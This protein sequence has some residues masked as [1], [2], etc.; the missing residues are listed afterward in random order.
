MTT[1]DRK[2]QIR[3]RKRLLFA[4]AAL[5]VIA[6]VWLIYRI[7]PSKR[8]M[9]GAVYFGVEEDGIGIAVNGQLTGST[10]K[11]IGGRRYLDAASASCAK[12]SVFY[13]EAE[14][15]LIVTTPTEKYVFSHE[16]HTA[17][18]GDVIWQDG[19]VYVA[20]S[21]LETVTGASFL[22]FPD[23]ERIVVENR[24]DTVKETFSEAAP[25][26][27]RAG[28]KSPVLTICEA[29]TEVYV[30]D[31]AA[32]G[33]GTEGKIKGWTHVCT[34]DGYAGYVQDRF[35]TD[36]EEKKSVYENPAGEYT[37][38]RLEEPVNMVFHQTTDQASNDALGRSIEGIS[39]V[40]VIAPTWFFLD[41][42]DG[43]VRSLASRTYVETAHAAGLKVFAVFNDFDGSVASAKAT[44]AAL[45]SDT[46]RTRIVDAVM[47]GIR[48]SGAD[49]LNL[50]VELITRDSAPCYLQLIREF[51]AVCRNAGVI[52]SVDNYVPRFTPYYNRTEQARVADYLV[53]MC[54][55]EHEAGSENAGSV[56]SLPFVRKGIEDTVAQAGAERTIA[57]LPFYTR[58][59][60][61]DSSDK[62]T[63]RAFGMSAA[64]E[65][66]KEL[67]MEAAWD[68]KTSQNYAEKKADGTTYRIWVEDAA[69]I[70]EKMKVVRE[71]SIAGVAEWK[72]GLET[73]DIW[74]VISG[75]LS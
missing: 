35:L 49:G 38:L 66:M 44:A 25:V 61:T 56:S 71:L 52:L 34:E 50:D 1:A 30:T 10:G 18:G 60:E 39:G 23:P 9:D 75:N 29:G 74:D 41:G 58:L 51:S 59:W 47:E 33:E 22:C 17:P 42:E 67:G 27:Y 48:T 14:N 19:E 55:D 8:R 43:S 53:V 7:T 4:A 62:T 11:M 13:D 6:G 12:P 46:G 37:S 16:E 26:R 68:E 73:Q 2:R 63:S 72:L 40:N 24:A 65:R 28:I 21:Y 3:K 45:S 32:D 15:K 31:V 20:L 57:A 70:E 5:A 69:S 64:A 36:P 54:Y